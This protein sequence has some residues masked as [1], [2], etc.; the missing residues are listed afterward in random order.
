MSDIQVAIDCSIAT[1]TIARAQR[2]NSMTLAMW[3]AMAELFGKLGRDPEVRAI[4][5]TGEGEHFSVGADISEFDVVREDVRQSVDYEVAVDACSDAIQSVAK[6]T[7]AVLKGY[8]LGG[9]CHLAMSCDFRFADP[10]LQ[11]GIPA[12]KLSIVYGLRST[13]RLLALVGLTN[14]KRVLF[15]AER[16]GA[17]EALRIGFVDRIGSPVMDATREFALTMTQS[18]PLSIA[19]AKAIL[20]EI[21]MGLGTLDAASAQER[22]DR[23]SRSDDYREGRRAFVEK[24]SP[25]FVGR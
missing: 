14:A 17:E 15:A 24:R 3:R 22:I 12:A 5:L 13:Q 2:R 23:A 8:C 7:V 19:G 16:F 21:S 25:R 10:T 11:I 1:V 20:N 4:L 9:G 6:P 18:A